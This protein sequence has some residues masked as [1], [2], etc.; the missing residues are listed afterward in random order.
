MSIRFSRVTAAAENK[1]TVFLV[2]GAPTCQR[3]LDP[4]TAFRLFTRDLSANECISVVV[5]TF[6]YG[7]EEPFEATSEEIAYI[8]MRED[9]R[10]GFIDTRTKKSS[11]NSFFLSLRK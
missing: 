9:R 11:E 4:W 10:P 5:E 2:G 8:Y 3:D 1:A 7:E 6:E